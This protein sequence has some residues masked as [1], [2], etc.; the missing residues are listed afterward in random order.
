MFR[1]SRLYAPIGI[2]STLAG[3]LSLIILLATACSGG[4]STAQT[5]VAN[6]SRSAT[7]Q[8]RLTI[9][10]SILPSGVVGGPYGTVHFPGGT[11]CRPCPFYFTLSAT[12]GLKPYTWSWKPSSGSSLPPGLGVHDPGSVIAGCGFNCGYWVPAPARISGMPIVRGIY[13]VEIT[14]ADS[15]SP[16][17]RTSTT[18]AI[19]IF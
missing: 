3:A 10:S 6:P 4:G 9:S 16:P 12:G 17:N 7:P 2:S 8:A 14:V 5:P 19:N 13:E 11:P 15:A 1:I 18:Y